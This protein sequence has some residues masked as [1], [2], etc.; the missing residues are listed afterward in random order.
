M[1]ETK[2]LIHLV[3]RHGQTTLNA[4]NAFRSRLDPHLDETGKKQAED[5]AEAAWDVGI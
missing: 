4:Q 5:A 1:S 3:Q 2:K